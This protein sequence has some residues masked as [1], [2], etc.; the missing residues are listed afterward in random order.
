MLGL[1]T[2]NLFILAIWLVLSVN[3]VDSMKDKNVAKFNSEVKKLQNPRKSDLRANL[4]R[5]DCSMTLNT[6][7]QFGSSF[8]KSPSTSKS[9]RVSLSNIIKSPRYRSSLIERI[10]S[11]ADS[12]KLLA[13]FPALAKLP[14]VNDERKL[15]ELTK[16]NDTIYMKNAEKGSLG[17]NKKNSSLSK[18]NSAKESQS[19]C[20]SKHTAHNDNENELILSSTEIAAL[21]YCY[22]KF[23]YVFGLYVFCRTGR[24]LDQIGVQILNLLRFAK[25]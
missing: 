22:D 20:T 8:S 25:K 9:P 18:L 14:N 23:L 17:V 1:G 15:G 3:G 24:D 5:L 6:M 16:E 12:A 21:I 11:N 10:R 13:Y 2:P 7:A 4:K 19:Q